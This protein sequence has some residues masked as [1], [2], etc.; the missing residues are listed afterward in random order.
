VGPWARHVQAHAPIFED[1]SEGKDAEAA[2]RAGMMARPRSGAALVQRQKEAGR[3]YR[4]KGSCVAPTAPGLYLAAGKGTHG[5]RAQ[6]RRHHEARR[7]VKD[8]I[9]IG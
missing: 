6:Q 2:V 8:G 1:A 9:M 4:R 5:R 7:T 3:S